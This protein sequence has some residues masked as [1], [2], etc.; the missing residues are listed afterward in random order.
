MACRWPHPRW[1]AA[2][3]A[4]GQQNIAVTGESRTAHAAGVPAQAVHFLAARGV[5][6]S[7]RVVSGR[8]QPFAIRREGRNFHK[9]SMSFH[10]DKFLAGGQIP[11]ADEPV[12]ASRGEPFA[13]G[14]ER[15]GA[16]GPE[17]FELTQF[18]PGGA[19]VDAGGV[20]ARGK[21]LISAHREQFAIRRKRDGGD[22]GGSLPLTPDSSS[23]VAVSQARGGIGT[24]GHY[25]LAVGTQ[26]NA[27]HPA[28]LAFELTQFNTG[29]GIPE[30][31]R[32]VKAA[33][34]GAFAVG[35]QGHRSDAGLV[36]LEPPNFL[37]LGQVPEACRAVGRADE[38]IL[39]VGR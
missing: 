37:A 16:G 15:Q 8:Q 1:H 28:V 18:P 31:H 20:L 21:I 17:D 10:L 29:G 14:G 19:I 12:V 30:P 5:P 33:G 6:E 34:Q 35:S 7:G 32:A 13:V 9:A 23:P 38:Q 11:D 3:A 2:V 39:A 25:R 27:V 26:G 36:P 22:D 4:G 24:A